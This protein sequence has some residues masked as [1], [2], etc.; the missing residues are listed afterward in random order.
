MSVFE[1]L[2]E[3]IPYDSISQ[4][5]AI[6]LRWLAWWGYLEKHRRALTKET[7]SNNNWELIILGISRCSYY[8]HIIQTEVCIMTSG[9]WI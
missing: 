5:C 2:I 4:V 8:S 7:T 9:T 1:V 3:I 6:R